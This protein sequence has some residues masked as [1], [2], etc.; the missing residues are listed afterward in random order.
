VLC[1]KIFDTVEALGEALA[2]FSGTVIFVSHSR[3]FV[4]LLATSILDIRDGKAYRYPYPYEIY[5][6]EL[7]THEKFSL[8]KED[9]SVTEGDVP[10]VRSKID[11]YQDMQ[12]EKRALERF[13]QSMRRLSGEKDRLLSWYVSHP[14]V[15]DIEKAKRL[16]EIDAEMLDGEATWFATQERLESL[17]KELKTAKNGN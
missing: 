2:E 11:V 14:T 12:K 10:Y 15:V 1:P 16:K 5:V 13:E 7:K 6:H 4:S 9:E 3:T 17:A 8:P